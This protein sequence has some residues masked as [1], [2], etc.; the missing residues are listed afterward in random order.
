MRE[1]I[2]AGIVIVN[3]FLI[4][5]TVA[6]AATATLLTGSCVGEGAFTLATCLPVTMPALLLGGVFLTLTESDAD[7]DSLGLSQLNMTTSRPAPRGIGTS[8]TGTMLLYSTPSLV[9]LEADKVRLLT[10]PS[11]KA[12]RM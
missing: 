10:G 6:S 8:R 9:L 3:P 4:V 11:T 5:V 7:P 1:A 2:P 12:E